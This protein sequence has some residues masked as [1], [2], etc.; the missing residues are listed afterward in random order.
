MGDAHAR[1][2]LE[3][4]ATVQ[5][6]CSWKSPD[7]CEAVLA[8]SFFGTKGGATFRNVDGSFHEFIAERFHGS[9]RQTVAAGWELPDTK[10]IIDW[11][12]RLARD[13]RYSPH[14]EELATVADSLDWI[15]FNSKRER[16]R[17]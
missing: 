1:L 16:A 11:T 15:Y 9:Q 5:I 14:I 7:G 2:D 6:S 17:A 4:G 13:G 10:A 12:T 8:A 3:T